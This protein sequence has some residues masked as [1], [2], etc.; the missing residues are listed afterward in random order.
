MDE[1][2]PTAETLG[3]LL[4]DRDESLAVAESLTGGLVGSRVTDVPGASAYFDRGF[5]TYAY[6][7]KR[8]L[9]GVSRESLDADGAVSAAVAEEMAAGARDHA[10]TTW[11][12]ATTGTAGP[13]GGTPEKPVGLVYVGVAYAA[14]WGT[15]AS[16]VRSERALL[17]GDRSDVKRGAVD[18]ALDALVRA[19]REVDAGE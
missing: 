1:T 3:D 12:V 11:A 4:T 17:D 14:P 8:E 13:S 5:V 16:F 2:K 18:A 15:E 9:L 19:I 6:D 10:D 7:A